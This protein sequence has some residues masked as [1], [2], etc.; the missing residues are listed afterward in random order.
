[1]IKR[2]T[3]IFCSLLILCTLISA[4]EKEDGFS[5]DMSY[6]LIEANTKT[7]LEEH[8][9]HERIN[10]GYMNKLMALLI[11]AEDIESGKYTI[12][13][14]L[15]ASQSVSGT[16]GSLVWLEPG[17]KMNVEEL[18]KG[19][20]IGNANDALTVLAERSA[21][22]CDE[23]VMQMNSRAFDLG[24]RDTFYFSPHGYYDER[25][26][27]TAH[28][29]AIICS[30]LAKYDF[31][32]PYF[33]TWRDFVRD[34]TVELVNE[35]TLARTYQLHVGFKA[36]H[37]EKTGYCIAEGGKNESGTSFISVVLGAESDD[38]SFKKS[39][40]LI[41]GAFSNYKVTDSY[42]P[43][44]MIKP[45]KV[46]NGEES[47]VELMLDKQ[48]SIVVPKGTD[49]LRIVCVFPEYINAPAEKGQ[50][51]GTAVFYNGKKI[52]FE[53]DIIVKNDVKKISFGYVL[54]KILLNMTK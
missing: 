45:I 42:F 50:K 36:T 46:K 53:T 20:I 43:D 40:Q 26:F 19:V 54:K 14:E 8:K 52:V 28:D 21:G 10:A 16:K 41:N 1:M 32:Q 33:K 38:D 6:I 2:I 34:G 23:F 4:K 7:V 3:A 47:A 39:K 27:T 13:T 5:E 18:L 31:L 9:S 11:I 15:T 17:D 48:G 51:V 12:E 22:S 24:L 35:N 25:E 49:S 29:I 30:E 37:S 44:E